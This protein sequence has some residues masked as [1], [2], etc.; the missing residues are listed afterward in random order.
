[1]DS[2][3]LAGWLVGRDDHT[4]AHPDGSVARMLATAEPASA[5]ATMRP[6]K[7]FVVSIESLRAGFR[8]SEQTGLDIRGARLLGD[9]RA[10]DKIVLEH[11]ARVT[12]VEL[13]DGL[14]L[15]VAHPNGAVAAPGCTGCEQRNDEQTL[16]DLVDP[17]TTPPTGLVD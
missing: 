9:P 6:V 17:H 11:A 14:T 2:P 10:A 8:E 16:K 4:A 13:R 15:L 7:V 12:D 1:M 3:A 5:A